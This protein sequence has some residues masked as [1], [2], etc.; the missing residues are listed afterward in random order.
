MT[1]RVGWKEVEKTRKGKLFFGQ[2]SPHFTKTETLFHPHLRKQKLRSISVK[3]RKDKQVRWYHELC[4]DIG[5]MKFFVSIKYFHKS[6]TEC[7]YICN[8]IFLETTYN[9]SWKKNENEIHKSFISVVVAFGIR[10]ITTKILCII[11]DSVS[12]KACATNRSEL[13][14]KDL[15]SKG[16]LEKIS[17]KRKCDEKCVNYAI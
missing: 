13:G 4:V 5:W 17:T 3:R 16:T 9:K 11:S 6:P 12:V 7:F 1:D 15:S 8:Q 2:H 14:W 10:N